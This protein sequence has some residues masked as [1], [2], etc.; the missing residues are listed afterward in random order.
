MSALDCGIRQSVKI[1]RDD[2][3]DMSEVS[4]YDI[5]LRC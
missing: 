5:L 1:A 4:M 2:G 3:F